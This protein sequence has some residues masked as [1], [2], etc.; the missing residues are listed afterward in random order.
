MFTG[1]FDSEEYSYE[2][3]IQQFTKV[4]RA[5]NID[6]DTLVYCVD[7]FIYIDFF[8]SSALSALRINL[9]IQKFNDTKMKYV[10]CGRKYFLFT[11]FSL[12]AYNRKRMNLF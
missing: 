5:V 10:L 2:I 1:V 3:K 9:K 8:I 12:L 6:S 4:C 11:I 7:F